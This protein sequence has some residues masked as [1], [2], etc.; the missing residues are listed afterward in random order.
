MLEFNNPTKLCNIYFIKAKQSSQFPF[1]CQKIHKAHFKT[2]CLRNFCLYNLLKESQSIPEE[3]GK[4]KTPTISPGFLLWQ[5][6]FSLSQLGL[7]H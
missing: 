3:D 4:K 5:S 2:E 1:Q 6:E 7:E